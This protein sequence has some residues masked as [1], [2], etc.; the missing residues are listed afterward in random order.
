MAGCFSS[1]GASTAPSAEQE[2]QTGNHSAENHQPP[3][4]E[5]NTSTPPVTPDPVTEQ[6]NR[7]SLEEKIGQL[8]LV[9]MD[10]T[11]IGTQA[12]EM[13]EQYHIGG[14]IFF[15]PNIQNATQAVSL[16]NSLKETNRSVNPIPLFLSVDEEGGRVSRLPNSLVKLPASGTVGKKDN[17]DFT[18]GLGQLLGSELKAFGLNVDFAPV[19]DVASNPKN[20][21]IGDRSFGSDPN[22][23]SR[24]G[25]AEMEGIQAESVI[26]GIKHFPGHGDTSVDSH[27]GLPIVQHNIKRL[28][29][30]E[31]VPFADAVRAGADLVMVAHILLPKL[32]PD[33]PS[34]FS[35]PII[36]GLLRKELGFG[37]VVITDD[38]TMGA[39]A[40][41]Y[42][43][44]AS[45]V[46]AVLAGGNI[47][48][49]GHEFDKQATVLHALKQAV[50]N[51]SMPMK[52]IDERVYQIL[53]LKQKYK[54]TDKSVPP[55][56]VK[57]LNQQITGVLNRFK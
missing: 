33:H 32:D 36:T 29:S 11:T 37:G 28:R 44:G 14:F 1:G 53:A 48:L 38:M 13:I 16:F 51:G 23:V 41:H 25:V 34:S 3:V 40:K 24:L 20:P 5:P 35:Q 43:I 22:R 57:Q 46:Q 31:L 15:K 42:D 47:V 19:M 4:S 50:L 10:G 2:G 7:L 39:I 18:R 12:K 21:V 9:G 8:V 30:V 45:A 49:V 54:L 56:N 6:L 55:V 17:P 52:T 27:L 26:P